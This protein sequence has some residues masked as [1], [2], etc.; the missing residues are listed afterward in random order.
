MEEITQKYRGELRHYAINNDHLKCELKT[1]GQF[2]AFNIP[3]EKIDFDEFVVDRKPSASQVLL[4]IS[5]VFNILLVLILC[6]DWL[7]ALGLSES[8]LSG[9]GMASSMGLMVWGYTILKFYREKILRGEENIFLLYNGVFKLETDTFIH[10]LKERHKFYFRV[11]Y[12][13]QGTGVDLSTYEYHLKWLLHKNYISEKE[14]L[15]K[16][17]EINKSRLL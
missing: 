7:I 2:H 14:F 11:K 4:L 10:E 13:Y 6:S 1:N 15:E 3:F 8:M 5:L 9:I 16:L 12:L 17:D